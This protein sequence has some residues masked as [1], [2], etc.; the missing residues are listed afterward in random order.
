MLRLGERPEREPHPEITKPPNS[1]S[2]MQDRGWRRLVERG[3]VRAVLR[4]RL[5]RKRKNA[6]ALL[7]MRSGGVV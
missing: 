1:R 4:R 3:A 7:R 2:K 5:C 6:I